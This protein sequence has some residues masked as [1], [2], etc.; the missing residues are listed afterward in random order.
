MHSNLIVKVKNAAYE[1]FK[2]ELDYEVVGHEDDVTLIKVPCGG[3][4]YKGDDETIL[5]TL[6]HMLPFELCDWRVDWDRVEAVP[7]PFPDS[8][9]GNSKK[10]SEGE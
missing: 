7:I 1:A 6:Y 4:R 8:V 9:S 10:T 2:E 3:G 5:F